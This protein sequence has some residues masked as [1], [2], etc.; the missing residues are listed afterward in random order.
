MSAPCGPAEFCCY[1]TLGET[2][3]CKEICTGGIVPVVALCCKAPC[4]NGNLCYMYNAGQLT[5]TG[6]FPKGSVPDDARQ[7][8]EDGGLACPAGQTCLP[9]D[10]ANK[11]KLQVCQPQ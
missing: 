11:L 3:S 4:A 6:C 5:K 8:C 2:G 9:Y 10:A 1:D 7:L